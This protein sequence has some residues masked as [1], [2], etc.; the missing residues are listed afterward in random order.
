VLV[1]FMQEALR[2]KERAVDSGSLFLFWLLLV[3][4]DTFPFQ[5]ILR[6][7]LQQENI[8]DL[9]RFCLFYIAY[10]FQLVALVLS[11]IADVPPDLKERTKKVDPVLC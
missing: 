9:P 11:A 4:C 5:T 6:D 1:M 3:I 10:G 8:S 7:A 2:R